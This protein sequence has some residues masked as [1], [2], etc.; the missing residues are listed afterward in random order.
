MQVFRGALL[1][2]LLA[3]PAWNAAA[4]AGCEARDL[5]FERPEVGWTHTPLSKLKNDT[6]YTLLPDG[7]RRGVLRASA[8]RSASLYAAR[9]Q[10]ALAMPLTLSWE[11]K[12]DALVERADNRVKSREDAPLRIVVSFGGDPATLPADEQKRFKRAKKLSGKDIPYAVLMYIWS[13]FVPVGTVIPSAHTSQVK[14][15][16]V[17]SGREGLGTWQSLQRNLAEDYRLAYGGEAGPV[18]GIAVMTDTDNTGGKAVGDYAHLR[19]ACAAG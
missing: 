9:L 10:P 7:E 17:A 12:T 14:M 18:T 13:D 6:V 8:D 4:A 16:V 11:W 19:L 2:F 5:G 3:G 1:G 15:L